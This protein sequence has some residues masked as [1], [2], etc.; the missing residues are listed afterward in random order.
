M[1]KLGQK[2][3]LAIARPVMNKG[4]GILMHFDNQVFLSEERAKHGTA[5][6]VGKTDCL[7]CGFCCLRMPCIATP[8]ELKTIAEYLGLS[9]SDT[10]KSKMVVDVGK[11]DTYYPKWARECQLDIVGTLLPYN[12]TYDRGYCIFF[13]RTTNNCQIYDVRPEAARISRCWTNSN[14]KLEPEACWSKEKLLELCPELDFHNEQTD[15]EDDEE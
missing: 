10:I 12:R 7:R 3:H 8:D 11:G 15:D 1:N 13:D 14:H 9:V 4:F 6:L 5:D 2:R